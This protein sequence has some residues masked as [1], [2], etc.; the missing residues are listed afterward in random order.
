MKNA[1][2]PFV[3]GVMNGRQL[4]LK[5]SANSVYGFTGA[6]VGML[7]C[8]PISSSVTAYGRDMILATKNAVETTYTMK[9]GYEADAVVVY[10]DTD[11]VMIK[12]GVDT[13]AKSMALGE[14][15]AVEITKLFPPPVS[16]EFEK[17]YYPYLLMNKKRYAGLYWTNP[18]KYVDRGGQGKRGEVR[19][20]R[21]EAGGKRGERERNMDGRVCVC[22]CVYTSTKPCV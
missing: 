21:G 20:E 8:I 19:G 14:E 12:F 5:I 10:G 17:V 2:D 3:K 1:T 18:E 11:S 15:A 6:T 16:L 22:V 13:V 9:N 4:A 7:P